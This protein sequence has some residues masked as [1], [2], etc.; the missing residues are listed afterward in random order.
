MVYGELFREVNDS[1]EKPHENTLYSQIS[2]CKRRVPVPVILPPPRS[3]RSNFLFSSFDSF[4]AHPPLV[5]RIFAYCTQGQ[6]GGGGDCWQSGSFIL[7]IF[8]PIV[9][10]KLFLSTQ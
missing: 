7:F 6:D 10:T 8:G 2:K 5:Q 9:G 3:Q 4:P 1:G